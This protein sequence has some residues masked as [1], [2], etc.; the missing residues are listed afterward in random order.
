M[1]SRNSALKIIVCYHKPYTV[2][3]L[4]DG[5]LLPVQTGKSISDVSLNIQAD[6]EINGQPCDNIS[7]K[8]EGYSELTAMYWA[9]KNLKKL[10]PDVKYVGL[11]HYRR[12]FALRNTY[13]SCEFD[14]P[15]S[16]I[17]NYRVDSQ[18]V[19]K[20]LESGKIILP[21][22]MTFPFSVSTQY[23]VC[24]VSDDYRTIKEIIKTKFPDYYDDFLRVMEFSNK[25]FFYNIFIMKYEDFT[26]YCEWLFPV[27]FEIEAAVNTQ[28]YST[29]QKRVPAFIAE[30]LFNVYI[31]KNN[32]KPAYFPILK[33]DC[34]AEHKDA[35]TRLK[36]F[37]RRIRT[38]FRYSLLFT[39][40]MATPG[41]VGRFIKKIIRKLF[42][43]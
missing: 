18:K 17:E 27:L 20:I 16:D 15:E 3:P 12:F 2:P 5:I 31:R 13:F 9:W 35:L 36:Q 10:Y 41:C 7:S 40:Y 11:Y 22:Q 33:Y 39:I 25:C 6:N 42:K 1:N 30:R 24:H 34:N 26:K 29:Y 37:I 23:C 19:I 32:I 28:H 43:R 4:D 8:N 38:D 14:V 21:E